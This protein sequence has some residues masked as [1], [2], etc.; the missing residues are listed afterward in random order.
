[1]TE[2]IFTDD[3]MAMLGAVIGYWFGSRSWSKK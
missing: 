2:V 1:V 3:E